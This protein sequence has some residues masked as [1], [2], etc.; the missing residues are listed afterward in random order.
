[1]AQ[2]NVAPAGVD[3]TVPSVARMYD[4]FL[5]GKDNFAVDRAAAEKVIAA[6]P[7]MPF[8]CREN[9]KFLQRVVRFLAGEAGIRQFLDLGAGLP[10]QGN[11]HAIAQGIAPA[12]RVVYVDN[13]P[14]VVTHGCALL[15]NSDKVNVFQADVRDPEQIMRVAG[16]FLDFEQPVAVLMVAVLHFVPD[17]DDPW[18]IVARYRDAV[19]AG[20]YVAVSHVTGDYHPDATSMAR[21][22]YDVNTYATMRF[23]SHGEI[24]RFFDGL[25]VLEP[26]LTTKS[27]WRPDG[28]VPPGAEE[29]WG[30]GGV[31]VKLG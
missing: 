5:G 7:D 24:L 22:V 1:V 15:R 21:Q 28:L 14:M 19:P 11:V 6:L 20:S 18:G 30:Y 2:Q 23:R 17:D 16:E 12:S 10:T 25:K 27:L 31:G 29:Q 9:R 8:M 26:G 4:Y 3:M 13:D